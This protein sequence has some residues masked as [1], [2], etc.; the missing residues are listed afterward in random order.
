MARRC[1]VH[2]ASARTLLFRQECILL[3]Q[4]CSCFGKNALASAR[5]RLLRQECFCFGKKAP[6]AAIP[7]CVNITTQLP[8]HPG[9]AT[10]DVP[11]AAIRACAST[12]E[13]VRIHTP[14]LGGRKATLLFVSG[15]KL[16]NQLHFRIARSTNFN[17]RALT[18][19][20]HAWLGSFNSQLHA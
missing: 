4:E 11:C 10:P 8:T 13:G 7:A 1:Q 15:C 9:S 16:N 5:M 17:A 18:R 12:G 20:T 2:L 6:C 3:R 14:C 19:L